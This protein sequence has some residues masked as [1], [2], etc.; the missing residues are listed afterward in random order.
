MGLSIET[1]EGVF[2]CRAAALIIQD[3]MLLVAKSSDYPCYYTVGGGVE[4]NETSE[5]AVVREVLE[6]TGYRMEVDRLVFL[7]ERFLT[8][9]RGKSHEL[10]FFYL[11]KCDGTIDI[12]EG[13]YTDQPPKETLHWL[14]L[15]GLREI[16]IV[17]EFLR[18]RK[19]D[20]AGG[21]EHVVS[22]E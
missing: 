15:D 2:T 17:P 11:M 22:R 3:N 5:E 18:Y 14:P 19:L 9:D 16:N 20:H 12:Q 4:I 1:A 7:Q 21:I 6:E 10:V 13:S 8:V